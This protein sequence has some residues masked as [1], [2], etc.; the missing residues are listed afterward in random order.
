MVTPREPVPVGVLGAS[1]RM[2]SEACQAIDGDRELRLAARVNRSDN[3]SLLADAGAEVALDFTTPD[4]VAPNVR[5]CVDHGIHVVV[6]TTGLTDDDLD[7]IAA[8]SKDRGVSVFVAPNFA[9][10]AVLMMVLAAHAAPYFRRAEIIERHH[11]NKRDRP[12]GTSLRTAALM[13]TARSQAW[14]VEPDSRELLEGV[15][16][17]DAGGVRVHSVRM[18]G[19]VAHQ[20]VI[21]GSPGE[22]LTIRHDSIDR[23]SFMP[24]VILA[25]KKV[26][27]L[28]GL[29][30]G[31][32]HLLEI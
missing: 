29:T 31:L 17:G 1:G 25:L 9:M 8:K 4:A 6:G 10:G 28:S 14:S 18:P 26:R 20:E 13:N 16:G 30:I 23:T 3:L 22:T 32:E 5:W 11:E 27:S 15:G 19:S 2:G 21:L 24:G 12:S 7:D